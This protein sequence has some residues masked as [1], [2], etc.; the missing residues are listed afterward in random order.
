MRFLVLLAIL[1]AIFHVAFLVKVA[2]AILFAAAL[3]IGLWVLWRLKWVI[4]GVLG[5]EALFSDRA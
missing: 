3:T 5:L 1:F 4:L 2:F